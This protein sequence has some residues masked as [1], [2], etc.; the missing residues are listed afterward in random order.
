MLTV[1]LSVN[2]LFQFAAARL[3]AARAGAFP[4]RVASGLIT[5]FIAFAGKQEAIPTDAV[6]LAIR[7]F[8]VLAIFITLIS[9]KVWKP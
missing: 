3:K 9:R 1:I 8:T 2:L 5:I 4:A 7:N 6:E